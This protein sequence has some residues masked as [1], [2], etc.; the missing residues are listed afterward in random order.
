MIGKYKV[1]GFKVISNK[2]GSV[3]DHFMFMRNG[4]REEIINNSAV[5]YSGIAASLEYEKKKE[6]MRQLCDM[7]GDAYVEE[8]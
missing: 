8:D 1:A 2:D 3:V 5:L 6:M 4:C 7:M